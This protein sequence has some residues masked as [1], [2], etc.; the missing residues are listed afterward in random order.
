MSLN[1]SLEDIENILSQ[2]NIILTTDEL[3][4]V[5]KRKLQTGYVETNIQRIKILREIQHPVQWL[6]KQIVL[7]SICLTIEDIKRAKTNENHWKVFNLQFR[8]VLVYGTAVIE[9]H[10][11]RDGEDMYTIS[12]DDETGVIMGTYKEFDKKVATK[13]KAI[14]T[15]EANQLKRRRETGINIQGKFYPQ[16]SEES[17]FV[18]DSVTN[19][20]H[21][22]DKNL[23]QLH[24][25][26]QQGR[27]KE[28]V[29]VYAKPFSFHDSIR[30][31][32]IDIWECD[33][34]ELAW[35]R[36]LNKIYNTQYLKQ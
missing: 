11:T 36:N 14:F 23:K 1:Y 13:Q 27:L 5:K 9:N 19:L 15:R 4:V 32:I 12:I 31:H 7:N 2:N 30:L 28:K 10:F 24:K 22:I 3:R 26:F 18:F 8:K 33:Q 35:K 21:M 20:M 34:I 16:E 6:P 25:K 29:L 17:Q